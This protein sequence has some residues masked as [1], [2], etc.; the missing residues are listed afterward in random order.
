MSQD[1]PELSLVDVD[2]REHSDYQWSLDTPA[3]NRPSCSSKK[4][5]HTPLRA[6]ANWVSQR[7]QMTWGLIFPGA[8]GPSFSPAHPEGS[9][10]GHPLSDIPSDDT[11]QEAGTDTEQERD[12]HTQRDGQNAGRWKREKK[13]EGKHVR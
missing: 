6:E 2:Q 1:C 3:T 9:I 11:K 12:S 5:D 4:E 10:Q 7:G 13:E 8:S